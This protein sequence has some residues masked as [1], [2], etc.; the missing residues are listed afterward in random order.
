MM[1]TKI[2]NHIKFPLHKDKQQRIKQLL[3]SSRLKTN[4]SSYQGFISLKHLS[5]HQYFLLLM[6]FSNPRNLK[7]HSF[8][9][10]DSS[11]LRFLNR[12]QH[13]KQAQYILIFQGQNTQNLKSK[14]RLL[15]QMRLRPICNNKDSSHRKYKRA[16]LL[17]I[18]QINLRNLSLHS[19]DLKQPLYHSYHTNYQVQRLI[20]VP[21][22]IMKFHL[23]P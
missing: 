4:L 12:L 17:I 8:M 20:Q 1:V 14:Q 10:S 7:K 13:Y 15:K 9:R 16:I 6:I 23:M 21:Q 2:I 3:G 11:Y 18:D 5:G 19:K 22:Q